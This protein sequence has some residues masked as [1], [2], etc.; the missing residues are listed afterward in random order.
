VPFA[1]LENP[2]A[3][4]EKRILDSWQLPAEWVASDDPYGDLDADRWG[5]PDVGVARIP[6][7]DDAD[8]LLTQLGEIVPPDGGA[9]V[10][11]NQKRRAQGEV[12]IETIDDVVPV[13]AHYT[14]PTAAER[15][16]GTGATNARFTYM[17]LHGIGVKTDTWSADVVTWSPRSGDLG[18]EWQVNDG[19]SLPG[20]TVAVADTAGGIVDIGNCYGGWTLD[21]IEEPV[22]KTAENA[23]ALDYLRSGTRAY[24][25]HTHISYSY[26]IGLDGPYLAGTGYE[27]LFWRTLL[28][29]AT[30]IDAYLAAKQRLAR[31]ID[32]SLALGDVDSA[33]V[34]L[35]TLRNMVYFGRP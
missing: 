30:P 28:E 26:L 22:H 19:G 31:Q 17:V 15:I 25:A 6:S 7:S 10:L 3:S 29:G 18:G 21:T 4:G 9:F 32:D 5:V 24:V 33:A 34:T 13:Q 23:L 11:L 35:K 2:V 20:M 1:R 27:V 14:P 12:V 16:P 8:L